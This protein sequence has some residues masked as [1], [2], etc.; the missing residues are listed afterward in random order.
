MKTSQTHLPSLLSSLLFLLGAVLILSTGLLMG[1]TAL[2]LV[3]QGK[4]IQIQ[5][6]ILFV[7]FGFEAVILFLAA[8]FSFQKTLQKPSADRET[9]FN[10]SLWQMIIIVLAASVSILVGSWVGA[11]KS[12]NW[13]VLPILTIPAA[14]LPLGVLLGLGT[15]KLPLGTRWQTWS[16]LGLGMTLI[17]FV[18]LIL[19]I[20]IAVILFFGVIAYLTT[21]PELV[22][23]L[24]GLS[25]QIL[26]LGPQSEAARELLS[27]LL[28]KPGVIVMALLYTALLVPAV[29]E[30]FKPL[31]VWLFASKL[32]SP[33][34]GFALGA[35]SG[36]S[37]ALIETIGVSGQGGEWASLLF[38]RIGTGL[39]HITTSALMG[40][41]IVVAIRQRN[42]LRLLGTYVLAVTLHG[43]WNTSAILYTFSNLAK[44]LGQTD[45]LSTIQPIT[46]IAM[47]ALAVGLFVILLISNQRMRKTITPP[48]IEPAIPPSDIDQP[49][50]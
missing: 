29:E 6:T 24:Q 7:A 27:P 30:I 12:V 35:L 40:A 41:A 45:R 37:Y 21:Q 48:V 32:D 36:A 10:L 20:V 5:Q 23:R 17:P 46:I 34:Q 13:L 28:T 19:E 43:L 31:G 42:Y 16:V 38:T 39:L 1:G 33:A 47:S 8:F 2:L 44:V 50:P 9:F 49:L 11:I 4:N 18:L 3:A 15:R 26:V 22:Y 14:V 25:Q